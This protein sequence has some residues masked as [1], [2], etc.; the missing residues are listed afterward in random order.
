M[1]WGR[2]IAAAAVA[3]F[4]LAGCMKIQTDLT[5]NP[6]NT[7]SMSMIMATSDEFAKSMDMD[8]Q[9]FWDQ[10]ATSMESDAPEGATQEPY[11]EDG[12][13]GV[14]YTVDNVPIET[15]SDPDMT[16]ERVG[17]EFVFTGT[18]DLTGDTGTEST[19]TDDPMTKA[20][21][22]SFVAQVS[23]TFP[24]KVSEY[25]GE[26]NGTTVTWT[27]TYGEVTEMNARGSAITGGSVAPGK[28]PSTEP[29]ATESDAAAETTEPSP[30][31]SPTGTVTAANDGDN[32]AGFPW[33]ILIVVGVVLVAAIVGV[34][35]L[36]NRGRGKAVPVMAG[37]AGPAPQ[38]WQGQPPQQMPPAPQGWQG[39][40]TQ[41]MPPAPPAPPAP[42]GWQGQPT[43]QMPPVP[44]VPPAPQAPPPPTWSAP[45]AGP[46]PPTDQPP[47]DQPPTGGQNPPA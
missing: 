30:T 27:P 21:M 26:L 28:Q 17:D 40:P 43:Q 11:A 44:P 22:D 45:P 42:Q 33:W 4:A 29:S 16:V 10:M 35:L 24:G 6:D 37:G 25:D 13:T 2:G 12:Y 19:G 5:L 20:I 9:E 18:M 36:A 47:T 15:L 34:V 41:Q 14:K 23:V 8:P 31:A 3:A 46:V 39:Q 32:A 38:A 7:G 1:R